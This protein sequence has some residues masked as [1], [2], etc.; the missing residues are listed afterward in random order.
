MSLK[1]EY[2]YYLEHKEELVREYNEQF[3]VL[4]GGKVIGSY[5]TRE[6]AIETASKKHDLGTFLVQFVTEGEEQ[7]QRFYSRVG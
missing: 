1:S 5:P 3:I 7:V 4:K 6:E 2:K